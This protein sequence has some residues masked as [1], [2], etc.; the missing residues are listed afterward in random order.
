MRFL[1]FIVVVVV[2]G[3]LQT[4]FAQEKGIVQFS[5]VIYNKDTNTVVPYVNVVNRSNKQNYSANYQGYFS[6]VAHEGDTIVFSAVG[7]RK[8]ALVIPAQLPE[9]KYTVIVKMQMESIN[10]PMVRVFPWASVDEFN[11][12]FMSMKVADD[13]LEIAKKNVAKSSILA[14]AKTLPRDGQEIQGL[15]FQN[16]HIS[17]SNKTIN[18]RGAN[19]LLDPF[20]WG[21]FIQQIMKGDKSRNESSD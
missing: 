16:N 13:D 1:L 20:K 15:N 8:E 21:A 9:K 5:G 2:F 18:Q 14:M 12:D 6:F 3:S 11:K 19:P 17:L 7:Y 4:S 10:L